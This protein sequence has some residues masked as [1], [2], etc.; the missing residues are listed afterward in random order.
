M[1]NNFEP[2]EQGD[3]VVSVH[4][5]EVAFIPHPLFKVQALQEGL[6]SLLT[7]SSYT[8]LNL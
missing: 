1:D 4:P 8:K 3:A 7:Q 6:K 5:D 2:L